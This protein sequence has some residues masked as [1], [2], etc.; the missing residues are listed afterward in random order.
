MNM[1]FQNPRTLIS[2]FSGTKRDEALYSLFVNADN[3]VR[4]ELNLNFIQS[5]KRD[6]E[7]IRALMKDIYT[8]N[9][10]S[11]CFIKDEQETYIYLILPVNFNQAR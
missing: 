4:R 3:A 7:S 1:W 6:P 5:G 10:K 8:I 11:P 2:D 9:A